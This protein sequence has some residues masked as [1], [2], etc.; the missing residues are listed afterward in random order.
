MVENF[1]A[2]L[3]ELDHF[4]SLIILWL[5]SRFLAGNLRNQ[6]QRIGAHWDTPFEKAGELGVNHNLGVDQMTGPLVWMESNFLANHIKIHRSGL[7]YDEGELMSWVKMWRIAKGVEND[8]IRITKRMGHRVTRNLLSTK[9]W[10]TA[11]ELPIEEFQR[12]KKRFQKLSNFTHSKR[13]KQ[14]I[15]STLPL[16]CHWPVFRAHTGLPS[17]PAASCRLACSSAHCTWLRPTAA[18]VEKSSAFWTALKN[19]DK[20]APAS[21]RNCTQSGHAKITCGQAGMRMGRHSDVLHP[22]GVTLRWMH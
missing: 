18:A 14:H 2:I 19:L 13:W 21:S 20:H 6:I 11:F 16:K 10:R 9:Q 5:W 15:P 4:P 12:I 1:L 3:S 17:F 8:E 22:N 7:R